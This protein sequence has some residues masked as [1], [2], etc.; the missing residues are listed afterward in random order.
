MATGDGPVT[1]REA[2]AH[3]ASRK[4]VLAGATIVLPFTVA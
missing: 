1:I 4:V 3:P 2:S